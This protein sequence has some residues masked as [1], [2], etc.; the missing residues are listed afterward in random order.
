MESS[1]NGGN[2][3]FEF[4][5]DDN[6]YSQRD[7]E[8]MFEIS[9]VG[10]ISSYSISN[11]T[12]TETDAVA[13]P[14]EINTGNYS[15]SSQSVSGGV[16][17][18]ENF[19]PKIKC[20]DF[21]KSLV[22]MFNLVMYKEN[23]VFVVE[24]SDSFYKK[25]NDYDITQYVDSKSFKISRTD[26]YSEISYQ[27]KEPKSVLA[28]KSNELTGDSY[29]SEK[30]SSDETTSFDGG[31]YK[32]DLSFSHMLFERI[33]DLEAVRFGSNGVYTNY[34]WGYSVNE[35]FSSINE[36]AL[37]FT[38]DRAD[39]NGFIKFDNNS[40]YVDI[41]EIYVP[42]NEYED[43]SKG[44]RVSSLNFGSEIGYRQLG[45]SLGPV[46]VDFSLF[47]EFHSNSLLNIYNSQSRKLSV[48]A[49]LPINYMLT[50]KTNDKII[51]NGNKYIINKNVF[52]LNTGLSKMELITDNYTSFL[53]NDNQ[54]YYT[55]EGVT[56]ILTSYEQLTVS[57]SESEACA[58]ASEPSVSKMIDED[59]YVYYYDFNTATIYRYSPPVTFFFK[60]KGYTHDI[61]EVNTSG[62]IV[63]KINCP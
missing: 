15:I 9:T 63:N 34:T 18:R 23:G 57:L 58:L 45:G 10:G 12:I 56:K 4:R 62:L 31:E 54:L 42:R 46:Q 38:G 24:T 16:G 17:F 25:G 27:Y 52:N 21:L 33:Q 29:G 6:W 43:Y 3:D 28:L 51:I 7:N 8:I 22:K 50:L 5:L 44:G 48:N 36:E 20:I 1:S 2:L 35:S 14:T 19:V 39:S 11:L 32:V 30:F 59:D 61:I 37:I 40:S 13:S 60:L 47:S 41:D 49:Y 55:N 26:I 53:L